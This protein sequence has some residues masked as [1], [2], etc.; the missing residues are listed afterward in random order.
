MPK[1]P[2]TS[3]PMV[4]VQLAMR[5]S[6]LQAMEDLRYYADKV[7]QENQ[8]KQAIRAYL[9]ALREYRAKVLAAVHKRGI[10]LCSEAERIAAI[11]AELFGKHTL[12]YEVDD[13]GHELCIPDRVP[14]ANVVSFALLDNEIRL[15]E[16]KLA[17]IGDDSQLANV[18][19]QNMLQKQQQLLAM[20]SNISK[21]THDEAMAI[22]RKMGS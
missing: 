20:L 10:D 16:E 14:R 17:A 21:M 11:L 8:K 9:I 12:A 13:I 3:D 22:I 7:K 6:Y 1:T 5:E 2:D 15:W 19:L 18:D 4:L